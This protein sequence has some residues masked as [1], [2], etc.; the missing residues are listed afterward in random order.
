MRVDSGR[1]GYPH[2]KLKKKKKSL[3][4]LR[5]DPNQPG[6]EIFNPNPRKKTKSARG[7]PVRV[8]RIGQVLPTPSGHKGKTDFRFS[9]GS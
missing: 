3:L 6:L 4:H 9:F 1:G 8:G 2:L 5:P 7:G